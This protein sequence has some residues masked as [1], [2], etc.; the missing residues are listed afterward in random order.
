MP[1][2][3]SKATRE[4]PNS[5]GA[6]DSSAAAWERRLQSGQIGGNMSAT[7]TRF[8]RGRALAMLADWTD[9]IAA[10]EVLAQFRRPTGRRT[11]RRHQPVGLEH[12]WDSC[13]TPFPRTKRNPTINPNGLSI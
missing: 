9:R 6:F 8:G 7:L 12:R 2:N 11:E 13:T 4:F 5:L 3:G 10:G 1:S